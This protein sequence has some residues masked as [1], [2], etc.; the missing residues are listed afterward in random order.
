[1]WRTWQN[2]AYS[3]GGEKWYKIEL[4]YLKRLIVQV[5]V[6][7]L[8][9]FIRPQSTIIFLW[10]QNY[11]DDITG[12]QRD[13]GTLYVFCFGFFLQNRWMEMFLYFWTCRHHNAP[14]FTFRHVAAVPVSSAFQVRQGQ[15][16]SQPGVPF[17]LSVFLY[18]YIFFKH[19]IMDDSRICY[20]ISSPGKI[21]EP[22]CTP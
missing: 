9:N 20:L 2:Q 19:H 6:H 14:W 5:C 21:N 4:A 8:S 1:M 18:V 7:M 10:W 17:P 12:P 16:K 13:I 15:S 11:S 3:L 22:F